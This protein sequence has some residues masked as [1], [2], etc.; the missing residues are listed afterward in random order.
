MI[1]SASQ[2]TM[3]MT[4][5]CRARGFCF[6]RGWFIWK[7]PF[8]WLAFHFRI[9]QVNP[10]FVYRDKA[11][12]EVWSWSEMFQAHGGSSFPFFPHLQGQIDQRNPPRTHFGHLQMVV[13]HSTN[14]SA[15]K[16][17]LTNHF[18]DSNT[19]IFKNKSSHFWDIITAVVES[20]GRPDRTSSRT[21]EKPNLN[22]IAQYW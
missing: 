1:P 18:I 11:V 12:K 17:G 16:F 10:S 8:N 15:K 9:V 14:H 5:N 4:F 20:A 7:L 19:F 22:F 13:E 3:S 21:L 2:N 6:L